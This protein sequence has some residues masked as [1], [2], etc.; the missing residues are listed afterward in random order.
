MEREV[1][2]KENNFYGKHLAS[3]LALL[4]LFIHY[5][6]H[7]HTQCSEEYQIERNKINSG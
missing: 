4:S 1:N 5:I 7:T 6:T 2:I 3:K